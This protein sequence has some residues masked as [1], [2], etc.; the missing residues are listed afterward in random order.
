MS[1][2][3]SAIVA[4]VFARSRVPSSRLASLTPALYRDLNVVAFDCRLPADL[5]VTWNP[6]LRRSAGRCRFL[7]AGVDRVQPTAEI[8]LSPHVLTS[9]SRLRDTLAHE[10]C[11]AAQFLLDGEGG[12]VPRPPHGRSFKAWARRLEERVPGVR[13]TTTH[14]YAIETRFLY[15]CTLC[16]QPYGRHSRLDTRLRCCGRCGGKVRLEQGERGLATGA[17]TR[18]MPPFAA[19]VA[20][21]YAPLRRRWPKVPQ[22]R[23]MQTLGRKWRRRR[24]TS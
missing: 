23:I 4:A 10:M 24:K 5:A 9:D 14:S 7:R 18:A 16:G 13:V 15:R 22:R 3:A 2:F 20:R 12:V 6:R 8:E 11:H 21:E 19:F 1:A 17:S